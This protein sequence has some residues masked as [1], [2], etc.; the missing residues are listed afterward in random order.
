M[1]Y[2]IDYVDLQ[3]PPPRAR[4]PPKTNFNSS[5]LLFPLPQLKM[6]LIRTGKPGGK[7]LISSEVELMIE[8]TKRLL[9]ETY[10]LVVSSGGKN[11]PNPNPDP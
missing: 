1:V 9:S 4:R 11:N 3:A 6:E 10:T 8:T 7:D 5:F 2:A